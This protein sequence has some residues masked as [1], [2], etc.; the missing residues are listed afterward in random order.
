[1]HEC[2]P[3]RRLMVEPPRKA[4]VK[5][6]RA[7]PAL[8]LTLLLAVPAQAAWLPGL[9]AI[10]GHLENGGAYR[11]NLGADLRAWSDLDERSLAALG[12]WLKGTA[13]E[14][15]ILQDG[16]QISQ[17]RMTDR[18]QELFL[19]QTAREPGL[20]RLSLR[21]EGMP[22]V[23]YLG[24]A[25]S[26]PWQQLLGVN[27]LLPDPAGAETA[28]KNIAAEALP[29][30]LPY[31]KP[32]KTATTIKNAGRGAS[33]LVYALKKEE[34]LLFWQQAAPGLLP[35]LEA[36]L[37]ALLPW[38]A[39]EISRDLG[40]LAPSGAL[41]LK[42]IL[43]KEGADLGLQL[44]GT[45]TLD[46]RNR[47]LT[48][49]GGQ[50]ARGA[51]LSLKLPA[52]RGQDTL[53]FQL[54]LAFSEGR[55]KGDW[56]FKEVTGKDAFSASGAIELRGLAEA[57]GECLTG[58]LTAKTSRNRNGE[59]RRADYTLKPDVRFTGAW[60][61]GTLEYFEEQDG[62]PSRALVLSLDGAPLETLDPMPVMSEINLSRADAGRL[63]LESARVR[64]A[65]LPA[66]KGFLLN[67]PD[68]IRYL[69]LHDLG[70]DRRA[71]D[72]RTAPLQEESA[73]FTVAQD[74]DPNPPKEENP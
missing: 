23:T 1:M 3:L 12:G 63:G 73:P 42:R 44:T 50:S 61:S 34:A 62:R 5:R 35:G 19:L 65:L 27:P 58:S 70:R 40:G 10:S 16:A 15:A 72:E 56:R 17:A 25:D 69:V 54:S 22:A 8:V 4:A 57:E 11:L 43:D 18:G 9:S 47:R 67:L 60:L 52:A 14:L 29:H 33:Q 66:L 48:L 49:F 71:E 30:L 24:S 31:E 7:L 37:K 51:Y 21:A 20:P 2:S 55:L 38:R 46:D 64:S 45:L 28:L 36:L 59:R 13:L 39:D 26:P 68:E 74:A 6:L 41:T 53:E 32:V